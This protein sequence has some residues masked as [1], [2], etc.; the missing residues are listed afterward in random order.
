MGDVW[1]FNEPLPL[2]ENE[3]VNFQSSL[4]FIEE[5]KAG[6]VDCV[7][8]KLLFGLDSKEFNKLIEKGIKDS[9]ADI[10]W[11]I[12]PR[13]DVKAGGEALIA[14]DTMLVYY[15]N[16]LIDIQFQIGLPEKGATTASMTIKI[17]NNYNYL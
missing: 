14:P 6:A 10:N 8:V 3:N 12:A 7:R 9:A 15:L 2:S 16:L 4:E 5:A 17:E 11:E 1:N 13:I